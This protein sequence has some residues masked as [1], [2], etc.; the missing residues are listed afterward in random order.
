MTIQQFKFLS[1]EVQQ[2][3]LR[4]KAVIVA[5]IPEDEGIYSLLQVDGFYLEVLTDGDGDIVRS[6]R[7]FDDT[8]SLEPYLKM[9][10][11]AIVYDVLNNHQYGR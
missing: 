8:E 6:I 7:Y 3:Y 9:I 2:S 1:E 5:V 4:R 10:N 11:I